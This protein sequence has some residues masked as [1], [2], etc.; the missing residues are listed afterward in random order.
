MTIHFCEGNYFILIILFQHTHQIPLHIL[1]DF[2]VAG[3]GAAAFFVAAEGAN[4]VRVLDLFVEVADKAAAGQVGGCDLV[5]RADYLLTGGWIIDYD[6]TSK[7]GV[8][9]HLLDCNIVLLLR[10]QREEFIER[11]VLISLE[12]FLCDRVQWHTHC[13]RTTVLCLSW[14]ILYTSIYD[15][16][17]VITQTQHPTAR[18]SPVAGR[19]RRRSGSPTVRSELPCR[20]Q[21]TPHR[22]EGESGNRH[23]ALQDSAPL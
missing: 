1:V 22:G 19:L 2:A 13:H 11:T 4:E 5:E 12:Y 14:N 17:F 21:P 16:A 18:C 20:W 7:A 23:T 6:R 9:K 8:K 3:E 10:D 15:T